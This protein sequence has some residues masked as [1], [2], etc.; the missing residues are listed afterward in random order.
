MRLVSKYTLLLG[1]TVTVI[2]SL[3]AFVRVEV[4]R[5]ELERDMRRDHRLVGRILQVSASDLWRQAG[6]GP[7]GRAR[8][9]RETRALLERSHT[10][11]E[12]TRLVWDPLDRTSTDAQRIEGSDLV[13]RFPVVAGA[14]AG[15]IVVREDLSHLDAHVRTQHLFSAAGVATVL[16]VCAL[17]S[18]AMGTWL[19]GRPVQALVER[20][21]KIGQ[22]DFSTSTGAGSADAPDTA[23]RRRDELGQLARE[24]Q[25]ASEA[26]AA[27]LAQTAAEAEARIRAIEQLRHSDRLATVG[28]LAAGIAHELGTPLSVVAGHAQMIAGGEVTGEAALASARSIDAEV[29]RMG[30]IVRQL[31]DF[32]RRK[33]PEG[34]ACAPG[35]VAAR[36]A[37]LL[38]VMAEKQGVRI[39]VEDCGEPAP[40]ALID[41]D[42]LQQVLTNLMVNSIQAMP[43]GGRLE[44]AIA[45]VR[46]ARE[47]GTPPR[48]CVEL[49]VRDTGPGVPPEVQ[50]HM[51]EP[52]VTTK[53]PGEGTGLGLAVVHGIVDDHGG[54]ITVDTGARGTALSLYLEAAGL[55]AAGLEAAP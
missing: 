41:E 10:A 7:E 15:T 3:I 12:A 9:D 25:T 16:L 42:S 49:T 38:G 31:L 46:A 53:A 37:S 4:T 35:E 55:E 21:R 28:K 44:V 47:P 30:K 27:S 36:C 19:V 8:A 54:W 14:R 52:F 18:L 5:G 2:L 11:L 23:L 32:A 51:F 43:Q 6:D 26:L 20:A 39:E 34:T 40:R 13:S 48:P 50:T 45:R 1:A 24:L 22:R 29:T 33:G 17:A